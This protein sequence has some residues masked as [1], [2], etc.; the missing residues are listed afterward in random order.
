MWEKPN[1]RAMNLYS[2]SNSA[3]PMPMGPFNFQV[4]R[5]ADRGG[6]VSDFLEK[7]RYKGKIIMHNIK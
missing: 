4:L 6:G 3:M 7:K 1:P 2:S 5:N